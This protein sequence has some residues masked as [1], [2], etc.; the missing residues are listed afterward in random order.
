[1]KLR[2]QGRTTLVLGVVTLV[3]VVIMALSRRFD[4]ESIARVVELE[5]TSRS[6][7]L[8]AI[9]RLQS[10]APKSFAFDYSYWDDTVAFVRA[11]EI[12][13][14]WSAAN[15]VESMATFD[16]DAVWILR[17][18]GT[19]FHSEIADGMS[20]LA[21]PPWPGTVTAIMFGRKPINDFYVETQWG[22]LELHSATIVPSH[23]ARHVSQPHGV[24]VVGRL[25]NA[26]RIETLAKTVDA[27][28]SIVKPSSIAPRSRIG[29]VVV[30]YPLPGPDGQPAAKIRCISEAKL[31]ADL[32]RTTTERL[33]LTGGVVAFIT[34]TIVFAL[35]HWIVTPIVLLARSL[36]QHRPEILN[37]MRTSPTE[38]GD[39]ARLIIDFFAQKA[40]LENEIQERKQLEEKLNQL[41][42]YDALTGLPNRVLFE[43]RARMAMALSMRRGSQCGVMMLD[44][45]FFKQVN[46]TMGHDAGDAVLVAVAARLSN[47]VRKNDTAAR[48]GGDEFAV[49][50]SDVT[51][52]SD[53]ELVAERILRSIESPLSIAG[54]EM[55]ISLS[56]G[57]CMFPCHASSYEEL[58]KNADRAMYEAKKAGRNRYV[59]WKP[60]ESSNA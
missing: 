7:L 26:A 30:E 34:L 51:H 20:P 9:V 33:Y 5:E 14:D 55:T 13:K 38:H 31:L 18:D 36:S 35:R 17:A 27:K 54:Q 41:A 24:F 21:K 60:N 42:L 8:G 2:I 46:D 32:A 45:D 3:A 44:L 53:G 23:D 19:T 6:R 40:A 28:V 15:I 52:P 57:L 48:L 50:I 10:E 16:A 56:I 47:C 12:D 58:L 39:L 11:P 4:A 22:V 49:M 25:W 1:M 37:E 59:V 29:T 43:D